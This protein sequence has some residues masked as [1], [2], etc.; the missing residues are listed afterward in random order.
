MVGVWPKA[1]HPPTINLNSSLGCVR[2]A[3]RKPR[4]LTLFQK[5]SV[6]SN[7]MKATVTRTL[8][9]GVYLVSFTFSDFTQEELAKMR[10]FGVP[11]VQIRTGPPGSHGVNNLPIT[12]INTNFVAGFSAEQ[13]AKN[14]ETSVLAQAKSGIEAIRQR[15]DEFSSTTEVEI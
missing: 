14:Y 3:A 11:V 9:N 13:E 4:E 2:F 5:G 1:C 10:S 8:Q 15:K 6:A 12:A 7:Q